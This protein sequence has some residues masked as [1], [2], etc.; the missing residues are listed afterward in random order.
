M[1]HNGEVWMVGGTIED[2]I[3]TTEIYNVEEDAWRPGPAL[4]FP[5]ER[6]ALVQ[7][8][9]TQKPIL[10]GGFNWDEGVRV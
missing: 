1:M 10:V 3:A 7:D 9:V 4:P 8:P 5:I 2:S 6:A